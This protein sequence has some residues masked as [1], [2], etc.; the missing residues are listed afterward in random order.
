M[1]CPTEIEVPVVPVQGL[2]IVHPRIE[3]LLGQ[4]T[5]V[6]QDNQIPHS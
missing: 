4:L 2:Q 1:R 3:G 6:R 5:V